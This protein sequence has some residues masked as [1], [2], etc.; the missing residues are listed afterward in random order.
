MSLRYTIFEAIEEY[1][2]FS[3]IAVK[4]LQNYFQQYDLL[5]GYR[6]GSIAK[7]GM[8]KNLHYEFHGTGCWFEANGIE[9][10]LDF[11]Q[12]NRSDGFDAWRLFQFTKQFSKYNKI[13]THENIRKELDMLYAEG[14]LKCLNELPNPHL[15]Y[16]SNDDERQL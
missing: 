3:K 12:N 8:I 7:I 4:Q 9:L 15:Y 2:A 14:V 6:N 5:T 11:G 16:L 13:F 10:N 1:T